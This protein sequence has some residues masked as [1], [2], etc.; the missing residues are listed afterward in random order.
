MYILTLSHFVKKKEEKPRA[1]L[2]ETQLCPEQ[3]FSRR[4][5]DYIMEFQLSVSNKIE[6]Y[7]E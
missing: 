5:D 6:K 3:L 2:E 1:L 4:G 7:S